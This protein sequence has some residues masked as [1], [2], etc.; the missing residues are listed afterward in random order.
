MALEINTIL[1]QDIINSLELKFFNNDTYY[2]N[3]RNEWVN[4]SQQYPKDVD[5]NAALKGLIEDYLE[6]QGSEYT[7]ADINKLHQ[8]VKSSYLLQAYIAPESLEQEQ[9]VFTNGYVDKDGWHPT[10]NLPFTPY[11]IHYEYNPAVSEHATVKEFL[12]SVQPDAK[13]RE[14]MLKCLA[15]GL[16]PK[17]WSIMPVFYS[18]HS[19]SG[20]GTVIEMMTRII[21]R[22]GTGMIDGNKWLG[23]SSSNFA[24]SNINN[25]LLVTMDEFPET[26]DTNSVD[27]LKNYI[28]S[29]QFIL[30]EQKGIDSQQILN[31]QT[32]IATTNNPLN[33]YK[34]DDAIKQRIIYLPFDMNADGNIKFSIDEVE[35]M[36]KT[37][38]SYF[39]HQLV[40]HFLIL[41][42]S[43]GKRNE[44]FGLEQR[45]KSV[46][47][48]LESDS[49]IEKALEKS[50]QFATLWDARE[51]FWA[52]EDLRSFAQMVLPQ[53]PEQ[54]ALV[55][56]KKEM[57]AYLAT[58]KLGILEPST[59]K[60]N[61]KTTKGISVRWNIK[62]D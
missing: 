32:F 49:L 19:T 43:T 40:E 30:I 10:T 4:L 26:L 36:M 57:T 6:Y 2:L 24:L 54:S 11:Q 46:W 31:T 52:N 59:K 35:D 47:E 33:F 20:K 50:K 53:M 44:R 42:K 38:I 15:T 60:I 8:R 7:T 29:K 45:N 25:K 5:M 21:G 48:A 22:K 17:N 12:E 27:V 62:E 58:K 14:L 1:I 9:I 18:A 3:D 23:K 13:Q 28:D 39:L 34:I 61:G 51:E 55:I 41:V 56:F 37:G 16:T